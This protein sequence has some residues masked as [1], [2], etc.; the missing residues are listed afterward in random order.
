MRN[1]KNWTFRSVSNIEA[2]SE[3]EKGAAQ[4]K[5]PF[6]FKRAGFWIGVVG[7]VLSF[8]GIV[9]A[10]VISVVDGNKETTT[11]VTVRT[12]DDNT[13]TIVINTA[14]AAFIFPPSLPPPSPPMY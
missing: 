11:T 4:G 5:T 10:I 13:T 14:D 1:W 3:V 2:V 6:S 8:G 9:T 7:L 12:N